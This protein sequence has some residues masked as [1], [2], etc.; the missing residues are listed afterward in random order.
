VTGLDEGDGASAQPAQPR[1]PQMQQPPGE[2]LLRPATMVRLAVIELR[3][4]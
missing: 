4:Y 3:L 2:T 1:P